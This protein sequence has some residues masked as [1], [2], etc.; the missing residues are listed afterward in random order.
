LQLIDILYD[1]AAT[2][3]MFSFINWH[4]ISLLPCFLLNY[5]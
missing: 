5:V 3:S 1:F 2:P 4:K